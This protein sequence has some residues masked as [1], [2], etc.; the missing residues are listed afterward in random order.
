MANKMS[1]D[2]RVGTLSALITAAVTLGTAFIGIVP[3]LRRGDQDAIDKLRQQM[4]AL[5]PANNAEP[6]RYTISGTLKS[7]TGTPLTAVVY[8][9]ASTT[10]G[11]DGSFSFPGMLHQPYAILVVDSGTKKVDQLG[12]QPEDPHR[13]TLGA[14][15][16]ITYDYKKD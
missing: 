7:A 4:A 9:A 3:Q 11:A 6:E 8:V 13:E 10:S 14:G 12:L 16:L 2:T 1:S 5:T 15:Y